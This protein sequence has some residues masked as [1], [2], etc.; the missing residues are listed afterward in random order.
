MPKRERGGGKEG[1]IVEASSKV[2]VKTSPFYDWAKPS[3]RK[4]K[5]ELDDN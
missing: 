2:A 4:L 3:K 5:K 1:A